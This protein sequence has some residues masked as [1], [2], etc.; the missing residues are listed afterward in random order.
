MQPWATPSSNLPQ[1]SAIF[2]DTQ[3]GNR[4][5]G[6]AINSKPA[7]AGFIFIL[8]KNSKFIKFAGFIFILRKNSKF[9]KIEII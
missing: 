4:P 2:R 9:I 7:F 6:R 1:S 3:F 5:L 8:R